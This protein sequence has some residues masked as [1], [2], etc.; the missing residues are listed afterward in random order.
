MPYKVYLNVDEDP[1]SRLS[2]VIRDSCTLA[3]LR[4]TTGNWGREGL[5]RVLKLEQELSA[6]RAYAPYLKIGCD[7]REGVHTCTHTEV[8]GC[9][10]PTLVYLTCAHTAVR[11]YRDTSVSVT[12]T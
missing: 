4:G 2:E 12:P 8:W 11:T 10:G 6:L 7:C 3:V 9:G 1:A 5:A